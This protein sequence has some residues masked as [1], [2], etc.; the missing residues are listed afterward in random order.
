MRAVFAVLETIDAVFVI[1]KTTACRS[2]IRF[3]LKYLKSKLIQCCR[4]FVCQSYLAFISGSSLVHFALQT[5]ARIFNATCNLSGLQPSP[6][7]SSF[8]L[9]LQLSSTSSSPCNC[10]ACSA[11]C[12][13]HYN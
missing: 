3:H 6:E 11:V 12:H 7:C 10:V 5:H 4:V 1:R 9:H 2:L 13:C 8:G